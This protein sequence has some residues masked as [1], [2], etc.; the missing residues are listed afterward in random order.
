[1]NTVDI[2]SLQDARIDKA[3]SGPSRRPH[4]LVWDPPA[5]RGVWESVPLA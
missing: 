1:M 3:L 2:Q 4:P 5:L